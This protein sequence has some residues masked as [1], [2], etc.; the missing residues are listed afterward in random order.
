MDEHHWMIPPYYLGVSFWNVEM[1]EQTQHS[2]ILRCRHSCLCTNQ[3]PE[4]YL[5]QY[6]LC[7]YSIAYY[8]QRFPSFGAVDL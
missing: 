4:T 5:L 8:I 1:E 7:Y 6:L 3:S 2:A